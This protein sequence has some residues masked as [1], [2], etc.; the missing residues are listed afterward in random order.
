MRDLRR[1]GPRKVV[2]FIAAAAICVVLAYG[3]NSSNNAAGRTLP[4]VTTVT[5][6]A[7]PATALSSR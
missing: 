6:T 4:G 3:V 7:H 1:A 5:V 2:L